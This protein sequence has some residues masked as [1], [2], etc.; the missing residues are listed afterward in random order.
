MLFDLAVCQEEGDWHNR[1]SK[2]GSSWYEK[3]TKTLDSLNEFSEN[4]RMEILAAA[5]KIRNLNPTREQQEISSR[6]RKTLISIPGHAKYFTNRLEKSKK[7]LQTG[8]I[9]YHEYTK[10]QESLSVLAFLPSPET[11]SELGKLLNDP[12]G[13]DGKTLGGGDVW[14]G[15]GWLPVNCQIAL[16]CLESLPIENGPQLIKG[17]VDIEV[18]IGVDKWKDWWDEVKTGKR[19]YRFV[20]SPI[21]YGPDGPVPAKE[22]QRRERER[23][24]DAVSGNSSDSNQS[25]TQQPAVESKSKWTAIVAASFAG[26]LLLVAGWKAFRKSVAAK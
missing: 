24:R 26:L 6:A 8:I 9:S 17:D 7:D 15:D 20:G 18:F 21:E 19:T 2:A 13:R 11:V 5:S 22:L 23:Q 25:A 16:S 4:D 12:V 3:W 1:W 14:E 10:A